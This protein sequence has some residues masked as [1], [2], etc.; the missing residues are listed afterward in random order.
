MKN[1]FNVAVLGSTGYVG[2]ELV[3]ILSKHPKVKVQFLGSEKFKNKNINIFNNKIKNK[4]LPL[5]DFNKNF[6]PETFDY[7]FL[8]LP[9]GISQK[10]V[11]KIYNKVKIIDLSA[12]FR[13]DNINTYLKSYN[14][15][16]VCPNF[17]NSFIYGLPE[18]NKKNIKKY[19]NIAVPGCYPTSVLTPL[20]PLFIKK[21]ISTK[22]IIIDS[23]SG[24]SGAGKKFDLKNIK[25]KEDFNFYNYNTN[26]HRHINEIQQELNKYSKSN[27]SFSFNP[28]ILPNYRGM[29]T[30][31]Y[32]DLNKNFKF[33]NVKNALINFSKKNHFVKIYTEKTRADFFSVQNTNN[34]IIKLFHHIDRNKIIIV[35]IIDNLIKGAAGQAVQCFNINAQIDENLSLD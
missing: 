14:I 27:V 3:K 31:I 22:N 13:L 17:F 32:C 30:T 33:Y 24:Y 2:L 21:I 12:D 26:N 10:Y 19:S 15:N 16:H 8:C 23:K 7:V 9:H 11:K 5:I 20:I 6:N 35:S 4:N 28:H 29:M 34:C 1:L 25:N 18:F